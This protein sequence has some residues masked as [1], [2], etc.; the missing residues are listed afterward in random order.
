MLFLHFNNFCLYFIQGPEYRSNLNRDPQFTSIG[1]KN[2]ADRP[3]WGSPC[4]RPG[5]CWSSRGCPVSWPSAPPRSR[6]PL[7]HRP[8]HNIAGPEQCCGSGSGSES[9]L[10]IR[11]RR[12]VVLDPDQYPSQMITNPDT[13]KTI[14][15]RKQVPTENTDFICHRPLICMII[16]W[17]QI[18]FTSFLLFDEFQLTDVESSIANPHFASR[19]AQ[20]LL[21]SVF[22]NLL[23]S[24]KKKQ[25]D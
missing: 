11:I 24:E 5:G 1:K 25:L 12:K 2:F 17:K 13:R 18:F 19:L 3:W 7:K 22:E 20:P 10:W 15:N 9:F 8:R 16:Y 14:E 23:C 6:T 21:N 4:W